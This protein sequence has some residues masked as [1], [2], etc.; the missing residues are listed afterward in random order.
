MLSIASFLA[1]LLWICVALAQVGAFRPLPIV[2]AAAASLAVAVATRFAG[3][4]GAAGEPARAPSIGFILAAG[5]V[6]LAATLP[7][8]D[9]AL[10]HSDATVYRSLARQLRLQ[11]GLVFADPLLEEVRAAG[12]EEALRN[13]TPGDVTGLTVR[14]PGGFRV[15]GRDASRV[16]APFA[17]ALPVALALAEGTGLPRAVEHVPTVFALLSACTLLLLGSRLR[18]GL[19]GLLVVVALSATFPQAWFGR[20]PMAEILAQW[21]VLAGLL[22]LWPTTEGPGGS[23]ALL[24]GM[25]LGIATLA[26]AELL[27]LLGVALLWWLLWSQRA[28]PTVCRRTRAAVAIGFGLPALHA[29]VTYTLHEGHYADMVAWMLPRLPHAGALALLAALLVGVLLTPPLRVAA[30]WLIVAGYA[31]LYAWVAVPA[32]GQWGLGILAAAVTVPVAVGLLAAPVLGV[33]VGRASRPELRPWW[34]LGL[35]I[36]TSSLAHWV[37]NP[38]E[39]AD[40]LWVSRRFVPVVLP[41]AL[42]TLAAGLDRA[43]TGR[44]PTVRALIL[45]LAFAPVVGLAGHRTWSTGVAAL[46][47]GPR[48]SEQLQALQARLPTGARLLVAPALAG[49]HVATSLSYLADRPSLLLPPPQRPAQWMR[50]LLR[51]WLHRGHETFLLIDESVA[52]GA[53]DLNLFAPH[54]TLATVGIQELRAL[55]PRLPRTATGQPE[56]SITVHLLSLRPAHGSVSTVDIGAWPQDLVHDLRGFHVPEPDAVAPTGSFRWTGNAARLYLPPGDRVRIWL[57]ADRPSQAPPARLSVWVDSG[58]PRIDGRKIGPG[59]TEITLPTD[60]TDAPVLLIFGVNSFNPAQLGISDDR[61]DL[62]IRLFRL[63]VLRE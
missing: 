6:M 33:W 3:E 20:L 49:T 39:A 48:T 19:L 43:L 40:P 57:S 32:A 61:R 8:T 5:A 10:W 35:A 52:T 16:T 53:T 42:L 27:V 47:Q 37:I 23:R 29:L 21:L 50:P 24:G 2:A 15:V 59:V 31:V 26:K 9:A 62:G 45:L 18:D 11:G 55:H 54:M 14:L 41:L 46:T 36:L 4:R 34:A 25:L 44:R 12:A 51:E 1:L 38:W 17:P 30:P 60:G 28:K 22:A 58:A 56:S 13:L 63:E 7:V